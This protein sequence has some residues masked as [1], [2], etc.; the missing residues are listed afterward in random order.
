MND[1][2][3]IKHMRELV[4]LAFLPMIKKQEKLLSACVLVWTKCPSSP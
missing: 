1:F 2:Y 4:Q 3:V